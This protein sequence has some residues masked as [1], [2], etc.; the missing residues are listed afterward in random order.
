LLDERYSF[1]AFRLS[2]LR[3]GSA[4]CVSVAGIVAV[5]G[6]GVELCAAGVALCAGGFAAWAG[7]TPENTASSSTGAQADAHR[8]IEVTGL[9]TRALMAC[10]KVCMSLRSAVSPGR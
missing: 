4:G 5:A 9:Y 1:A 2:E 8:L 3:T 10:G 7:A 6:S